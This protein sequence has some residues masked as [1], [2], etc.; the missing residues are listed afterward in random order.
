MDTAISAKMEKS[1]KHAVFASNWLL[2]MK[3]Y[4][5]E[6]FRRIRRVFSTFQKIT[7]LTKKMATPDTGPGNFGL[8]LKSP[9]NMPFLLQ[10][11]FFN[12]RKKKWIVS[13]E[14]EGYF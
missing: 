12:E 7:K 9:Q 13:E 2:M 1:S 6:C 5:S 14:L 10:T 4:I 3:D 8:K 11:D